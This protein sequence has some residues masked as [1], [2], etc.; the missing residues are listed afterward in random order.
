MAYSAYEALTIEEIAS[1]VERKYDKAGAELV[2]RACQFA[3]A[4]HSDQTRRSGEPYIGHPMYVASILTEIMIDP[5]AI[6]R[7]RLSLHLR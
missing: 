1:R 5:P 3:T 7:Q 4:A 6:R 2:T